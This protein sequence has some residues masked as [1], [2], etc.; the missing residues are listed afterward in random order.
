[1]LCSIAR[2]AAGVSRSSQSP[3]PAG[4]TLSAASRN[5]MTT[6]TTAIVIAAALR[7]RIAPRATAKMAATASIA[8]VPTMTRTSVGRGAVSST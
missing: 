2:P 8:A 1:M 5:G 7:R 6:V 4:T 3:T